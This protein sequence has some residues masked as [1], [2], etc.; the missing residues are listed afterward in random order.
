MQNWKLLLLWSKDIFLRWF[1]FLQGIPVDIKN[2]SDFYR[3]LHAYMFG[4]TSN[5]IVHLC[6]YI[7]RAKDQVLISVPCQFNIFSRVTAQYLLTCRFCIII[8]FHPVSKYIMKLKIWN[9]TLNQFISTLDGFFFYL[10]N[11]YILKIQ[12]WR[13]DR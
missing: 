7:Y 12:I 9:I 10:K 8:I 2:M 3:S 1:F 6:M 13:C 4:M 5:V 11:I